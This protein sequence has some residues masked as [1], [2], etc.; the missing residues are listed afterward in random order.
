MTGKHAYFNDKLSITNQNMSK[1]R[2][3]VVYF[4]IR[5]GIIATLFLKCYFI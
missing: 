4:L 2:L 1:N 5:Y 3:I